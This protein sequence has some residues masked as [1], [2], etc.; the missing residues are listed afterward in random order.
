MKILLAPDSFKGSLSARE[1]ADAM[2]SG[3][4]RASKKIT[5]VKAPL[6]DGGEGLAEA[7]VTAAGGKIRRKKVT[8]PLGDPVMASYGLIDNGKTAVIETAAAA[9]LTLLKPSGRNPLLATTFGVGELIAAAIEAGCTTIILGAGGSATVDGGIGMLQAL[10]VNFM[11]R[12]GKPVGRGG[13]ELIKIHSINRGDCPGFIGRVRFIVA[14]DVQ[15]TLCGKHG[16]AMV[17]GPQ[18]GADQKTA[19]LLDR[20]LMH[21]ARVIRQ[22]SKKNLSCIPGSG[23]AGGLAAGAC[24]ILGARIAFGI[25]I[26]LKKIGFERL[27]T[28]CD[29][30]ITGEGRTDGQTRFGKAPLGVARRA[31]T[32]AVPVVCVSGALGM[33]ID[34]LYHEGFDAL[35]SIIDGPNSESEAMADA[36]NLLARATENIV[37]L[38]L[39]ARR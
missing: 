31:A 8:G 34:E 25:D 2:A 7:L 20:G 6:S 30:V 33:K 10:G 35:F 28:G 4:R 21:F 26:V 11:D 13:G 37:R 9:G 38:F 5:T 23:A 19:A 24:A 3:V 39:S 22:H 32:H 1:A 29:L 17:Y 27:L 14:A 12:Q 16:A 15:N 18:K 36:K